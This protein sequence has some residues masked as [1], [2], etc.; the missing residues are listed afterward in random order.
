M[1]VKTIKKISI[2]LGVMLNTVTIA[3]AQPSVDELVALFEKINPYEDFS[4]RKVEDADQWGRKVRNVNLPKNYEIFPYI[5][6]GVPNWIYEELYREE[7]SE[8]AGTGAFATWGAIK[9]PKDFE[10]TYVM[11]GKI[12]FA[13][14]YV[15]S[16]ATSNLARNELS[17]PQL[18]ETYEQLLGHIINVDYRTFNEKEFADFMVKYIDFSG[19]DYGCSEYTL[20]SAEKFD[21]IREKFIRDKVKSYAEYIKKY[22]I[23]TSGTYEVF[24]EMFWKNCMGEAVLP[25]YVSVKIVSGEIPKGQVFSSFGGSGYSKK[26][27]PKYKLNSEYK[28][29]FQITFS[30]NNK[31][32]FDYYHLSWLW[33]LDTDTNLYQG[34]R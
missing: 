26:A 8:L 21:V 20:K 28:G 13:R 12:S 24:P 2:V 6:E 30:D 22:K 31:G 10:L 15:Q 3:Y 25:S 14:P 4:R 1:N 11:P 19:A 5:V 23:I 33:Q 32:T 9:M 16:A 29:I 34:A 17:I 18:K 7:G 27:H